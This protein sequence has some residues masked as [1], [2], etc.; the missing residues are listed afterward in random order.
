LQVERTD[1]E[2]GMFLFGWC[3]CVHRNARQREMASVFSGLNLDS[4]DLRV[5]SVEVTTLPTFRAGAPRLLF[6][7][8]GPLNGN[9][10]NI[11]RDG[12]RFV[13]AVNVSANSELKKGRALDACRP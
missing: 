6:T 3:Q 12:Q 1:Q 10:G 13:F 7:L 2:L 4:N 9:L 11:S 5:M 8:P